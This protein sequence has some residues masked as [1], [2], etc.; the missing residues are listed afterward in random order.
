[1]AAGLSSVPGSAAGG[2]TLVEL[3]VATT[4]GAL[5]L[6]GAVTSLN[7]ATEATDHVIGL[8][9]L[10]QPVRNEGQDFITGS[11]ANR[12]IDDLESIKIEEQNPDEFGGTSILDTMGKGDRQPGS[13]EQPG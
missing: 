5:V 6:L 12:I 10:P 3:L 2:F 7:L 1:M 13:I 11:M 4:V 8:S 9:D